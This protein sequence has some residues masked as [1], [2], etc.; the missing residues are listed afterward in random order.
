[1]NENK[2]SGDQ[3]VNVQQSGKFNRYEDPGIEEFG[4]NMPEEYFKYKY[5]YNIAAHHSKA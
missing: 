1:M 2:F 3:L 4:M 5:I